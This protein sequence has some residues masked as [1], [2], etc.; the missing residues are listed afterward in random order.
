[1]AAP[2]SKLQYSMG[3]LLVVVT[4]ACILATSIRAAFR[5]EQIVP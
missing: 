2:R 4:G 3:T 1:M 5:L